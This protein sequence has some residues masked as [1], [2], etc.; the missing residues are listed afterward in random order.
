MTAETWDIAK[1]FYTT[2][3][4]HQQCED[5]LEILENLRPTWQD[6]VDIHT[7]MFDWFATHQGDSYPF[8]DVVKV[9]K[10]GLSYYVS[11][12][13]ADGIVLT[14]SMI[15]QDESPYLKIESMLVQLV[16]SDI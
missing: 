3:K 5:M 11:F 4:T 15:S 1:W 6:R 9:Q 13:R 12:I 16:G 8:G 14:A 10:L 7:S 2:Y